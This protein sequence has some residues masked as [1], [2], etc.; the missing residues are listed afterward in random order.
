MR[1]PWPALAGGVVVAALGAFGLIRG[2]MPQSLA[3]S[4]SGASSSSPIVIGGA[5]VRPPVPPSRNA[6]AYFTVYNT[7][8]SPDR[9]LSVETGLGTDAVLHTVGT[10]GSMSVD[11]DGAVIPAHGSLTLSV[12]KGHVMIEGVTGTLKPGQHVDL[13]LDFA[14]AGSFDIAAPVV[15]Y[16]SPAPTPSGAHS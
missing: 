6:A 13:E 5:F 9:L 12:G 4:A 8:G 14:N 10:N 1:L 3:A 16:G 2:A 11:P 7:T 15:A